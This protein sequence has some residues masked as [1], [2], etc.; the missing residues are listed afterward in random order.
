MVQEK[1]VYVKQRP[2]YRNNHFLHRSSDAD[3][4][5]TKGPKKTAKYEI[6]IQNHSA[7]KI[8]ARKG[9]QDNK[10]EDHPT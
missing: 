10:P 1:P 5:L 6:G 8:L 2:E 3:L 9:F 7:V 4:L